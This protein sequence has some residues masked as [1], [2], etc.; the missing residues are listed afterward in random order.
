VGDI[1]YYNI[2][3]GVTY[4][5][6]SSEE[7]ERN[8]AVSGDFIAYESYEAGDS[9]IWLYSIALGVSERVTT[10]TAEQY[11]HDISGN[12]IVFTDN[13]N[14]NLDIYMFE[15]VFEEYVC[16]DANGDEAVNILDI[17]FLISYLYKGGS[18]PDPLEAADVNNSGN[19]NILDITYLIAYLYMGGPEPEC[20]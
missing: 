17:T 1:F 20:P 2:E 11:L 13:R 14:D 19:V 7:Y 4:Q 12:R 8:P 3:T 5:A 10:D 9:D 6:V 16:G 15:F 18:A